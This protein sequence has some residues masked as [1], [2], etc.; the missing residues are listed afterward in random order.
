MTDISVVDFLKDKKASIIGWN[1]Y[2]DAIIERTNQQNKVVYQ[3]T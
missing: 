1:A 2:S 3:K